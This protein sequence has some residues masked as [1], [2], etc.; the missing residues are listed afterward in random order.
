MLI[1]NET[2]YFDAK[3]HHLNLFFIIFLFVYIGRMCPSDEDL[4]IRKRK[5]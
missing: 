5:A 1:N 4:K 2:S 3:I